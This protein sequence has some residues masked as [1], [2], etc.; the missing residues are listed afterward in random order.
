M[1]NCTFIGCFDYDEN[2][3][4]VRCYG[5]RS[6]ERRRC[7]KTCGTCVGKFK[8]ETIQK[9]RYKIIRIFFFSSMRS[10]LNSTLFFCAILFQNNF[11]AW[12][13]FDKLQNFDETGIDCG[14]SCGRCTGMLFRPNMIHME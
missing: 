11:L 13:C 7:P 4:S 8:I 14:G 12:H 5:N 6:N 1:K 10:I 3:R 9:V 2:C